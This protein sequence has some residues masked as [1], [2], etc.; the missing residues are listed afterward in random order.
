MQS[1]GVIEEQRM[2]LIPSKYWAAHEFCFFL[3]DR[4]LQLLLEYEASGA[5]NLVSE[6]FQKAIAGREDEFE[7]LDVLEFLKKNDLTEPYK[8]H[9][10]SHVVLGLSADML[11]FLYESLKCFEKRKFSVAFSLLR[12]PLKEHLFFLSWL[13]ADEDDFI[14]RFEADNYES[15][16]HISKEKRLT[17][18]NKAISQLPVSEAFDAETIWKM[19][20]SKKHANGFEPTWQRATHLITSRGALLKTEDYSFNFIFEDTS[21]NYYHEFLY[22]NLPYLLIFITQI[23]F[24]CFNRI[25]A[26]NDRTVSYSIITTMGCYE[27]LF[28]DGKKQ[29]I[30]RMLEKE[31][32][33]FMNCTHCD[34]ALRINKKD[35]P[36]FYLTEQ[37]KCKKCGVYSEFPL[38]WILAKAKFSIIR[39]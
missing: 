24:E 28:L 12:K 37:I 36:T 34:S 10:I 38:Y 13:L 14:S 19:I 30:S 9:I 33:E 15:L 6:S 3:H 39:K 5:H 2:E 27:A 16:N 26:I 11:N 32:R 25:Q 21:D 4:L 31:L 29:H 8:H 17:I 20:Y 35:A 22:S 23:I 1:I 7:A 18:I